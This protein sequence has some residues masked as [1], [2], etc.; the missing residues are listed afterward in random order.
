MIVNEYTKNIHKLLWR[1]GTASGCKCVGCGCHPHSRNYYFY[2]SKIQC[3]EV[4]KLLNT[5]HAKFG[6]KAKNG[7]Y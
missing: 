6:R 7:V 2:L 4:A 1:R 5:Q 3:P